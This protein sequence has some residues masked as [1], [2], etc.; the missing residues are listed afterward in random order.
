MPVSEKQTQIWFRQQTSRGKNDPDCDYGPVTQEW[1]GRKRRDG[2]S[3]IISPDLESERWLK[4]R[5]RIVRRSPTISRLFALPS[6]P[7]LHPKWQ[8][9]PR[10]PARQQIPSPKGGVLANASRDARAVER[11]VRGDEK[12]PLSSLTRTRQSHRT[13]LFPTASAKG[14]CTPD[15]APA[16]WETASYYYLSWLVTCSFS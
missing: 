8:E 16:G 3:P 6:K 14:P 13:C 11:K 1:S 7:G 2:K 10:N 12:P 4:F 9:S 15:Y 5:P